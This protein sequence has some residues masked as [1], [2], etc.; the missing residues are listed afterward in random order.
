MKLFHFSGVSSSGKDRL[1]GTRRNTG[2]AIDALVRVDIQHFCR[3]KFRFVFPRMNAVNRTDIDTR[4]ILRADARLTDDIGHVFLFLLLGA[5]PPLARA[6]GSKTRSSRGPQALF[7][8]RGAPPPLARAAGS[9]TRSSRGP[10][11]LF[12]ARGAPPPLARAAGSKTRS[13]RG[14]QALFTARGAPPPLA[15]A[16]GSKT[17]SSRGPQALFTARGAPPPLARAAGSKTRSSRG[18][19]A[20]FTARGAPPPLA[21]AAGSKTR[22]STSLGTTLSAVEGSLL[23]RAAG[24][25]QAHRAVA[26][27]GRCPSRNEIRRASSITAAGCSP[28]N[29]RSSVACAKTPTRATWRPV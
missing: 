3:R 11:A 9:K 14:P 28:E 7:T 23:A 13:S 25:P 22:P 4:A 24:A 10:Q 18:P 8:A 15:R 27:A 2:A 19:Q 21:R 6:A 5:P 26:A 1:D 20:L 16:A 17:R 29:G 12:T